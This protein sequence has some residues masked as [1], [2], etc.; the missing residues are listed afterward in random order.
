MF[1]NLANKTTTTTTTTPT[2]PEYT[3]SSEAFTCKNRYVSLKGMGTIYGTIDELA[4]ECQS[5]SH[6]KAFDYYTPT[7]EGHVCSTTE[8][9]HVQAG[10]KLCTPRRDT[11]TAGTLINA[12]Y[13]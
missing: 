8:A 11:S 4:E 5:D 6:C 7:A 9:S 3:C 12:G 10:Y 1:L 13:N 2:T